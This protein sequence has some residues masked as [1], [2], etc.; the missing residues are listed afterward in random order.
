M[1]LSKV[2]ICTKFTHPQAVLQGIRVLWC[3]MRGK[4]L[5]GFGRGGKDFGVF[6]RRG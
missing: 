2:W 4:G 3:K 6:R 1:G 5:L